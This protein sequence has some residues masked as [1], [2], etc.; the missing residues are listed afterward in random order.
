MTSKCNAS[1][2]SQIENIGRLNLPLFYNTFDLL[3][4]SQSKNYNIYK[5]TTNKQIAGYIVTQKR[6]DE[7]R[8]HIMSIGVLDKYRNKGIG[9]QLI[10][11]IESDI[12]N[13]YKKGKITLYVKADNDIA[14]KFYKKNGF[15]NEKLVKNYYNSF[16][17]NDAY[18][19]VKKI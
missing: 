6:N 14:I 17:N 1:D 10:K 8:H 19:F 3:V 9:S 12:E 7:N 4:M 16:E 2:F 5:Y 11:K 13:S 15:E 18:Y